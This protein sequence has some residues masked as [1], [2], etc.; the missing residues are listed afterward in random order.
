MR[1]GRRHKN[2]PAAADRRE[3]SAAIRI[4]TILSEDP[5]D[6]S[7]E[8][9]FLTAEKIMSMSKYSG[10]ELIYLSGPEPMIEGFEKDLKTLGV[11]KKQLVT[12]FFPGYEG[13]L[14]RR[15][16]GH[17]TVSRFED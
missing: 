1:P 3:N 7:S 6:G 15:L 10:K 8:V 14:W 17:G 9:G 13:L 11:N 12:D 16:A 5:G 4:L 2:L